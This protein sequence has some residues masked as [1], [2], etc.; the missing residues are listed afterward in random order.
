MTH[1]PPLVPSTFSCVS[2]G[3]AKIHFYLTCWLLL[4]SVLRHLTSTST[5][6]LSTLTSPFT[7]HNAFV[8]FVLNLCY[9]WFC[10]EV[11][12]F[13][14][15][16]NLESFSSSPLL[17][18]SCIIFVLL[19]LTRPH[20]STSHSSDA[21]KSDSTVKRSTSR[22]RNPFEE[23]SSSLDLQALTLPSADCHNYRTSRTTAYVKDQIDSQALKRRSSAHASNQ[24]RTSRISAILNAIDTA[25]RT[26]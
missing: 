10:K 5:W 6:T 8:M 19:Q 4:P 23:S 3:Q 1:K 17:K 24:D 16:S 12:S 21:S 15:V 2:N 26:G 14:Y 13:T 7:I 20:H 11:C 9:P 18:Y 25:M 22:H